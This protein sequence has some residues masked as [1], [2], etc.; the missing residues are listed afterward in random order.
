M[1]THDSNIL[2][3]N[4]KI[5]KNVVAAGQELEQKVKMLGGDEKRPKYTLEPPL[6][7]KRASI[8]TWNG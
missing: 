3:R 6:G 7:R 8:H 4:R 2:A 5:D 1:K